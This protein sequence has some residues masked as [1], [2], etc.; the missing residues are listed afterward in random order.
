MQGRLGWIYHCYK[1]K[2]E[3]KNIKGELRKRE[4]EEKERNVWS[5]KSHGYSMGSRRLSVEGERENDVFVF[6]FPAFGV[7][8]SFPLCPL[9]NWGPCIEATHSFKKEP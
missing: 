1:E 6:C 7:H 9:A 5:V 4:R 3:R 2:R 8:L